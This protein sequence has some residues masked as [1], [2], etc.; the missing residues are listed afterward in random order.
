MAV[1]LYPSGEYS[2]EENYWIYKVT[3]TSRE[4]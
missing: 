1:R 3:G 2:G 4:S